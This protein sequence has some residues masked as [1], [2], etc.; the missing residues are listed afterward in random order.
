MSYISFKEFNSFWKY[1]LC[2]LVTN[3]ANSIHSLTV[4]NLVKFKNIKNCFRKPK[5]YALGNP[6]VKL[7]M[8]MSSQSGDIIICPRPIF[9]KGCNYIYF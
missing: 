8:P 4:N 3:G 7:Q 2:S 5:Y 1:Y 6:P 9:E